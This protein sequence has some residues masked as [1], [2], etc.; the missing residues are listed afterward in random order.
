M[1]P[2][3]YGITPANPALP[4]L[5]TSAGWFYFGPKLLRHFYRFTPWQSREAAARLWTL[6]MGLALL[7]ALIFGG[8]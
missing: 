1:K 7:L 6:L 5:F 3:H 4:W 8:K 2:E